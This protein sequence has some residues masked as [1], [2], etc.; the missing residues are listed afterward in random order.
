MR[1]VVKTL[2]TATV[3]AGG[4]SLAESEALVSNHRKN[5]WKTVSVYVQHPQQQVARCATKNDQ[6]G[7]RYP[8]EVVNC[9][10][11]GVPLQKS[12]KICN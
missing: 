9:R 5:Y 1:H 6:C 2:F 4:F 11:I 7:K 8:V 12:V 3:V 10:T